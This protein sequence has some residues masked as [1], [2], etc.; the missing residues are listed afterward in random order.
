[1]EMA[2]RR[3]IRSESVSSI[4]FTRGKGRDGERR[5]LFYIAQLFFSAS[6]LH[7][8]LFLRTSVLY[9]H[10]LDRLDKVK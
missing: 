4:T 1:M 10:E 5:A 7:P 6:V 2:R 8:K 9:G 3:K